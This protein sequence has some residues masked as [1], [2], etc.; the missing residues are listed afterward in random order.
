MHVLDPKINKDWT[1]EET[2]KL[3]QLHEKFGNKWAAIGEFFDGKSDNI[4]KD[5]FFSTSR[6]YLRRMFKLM[7]IKNGTQ[8]INK[9][10]SLLLCLIVSEEIQE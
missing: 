4:V 10:K 6:R 8:K 2:V 7:G 5:H 3:F 9:V 1:L